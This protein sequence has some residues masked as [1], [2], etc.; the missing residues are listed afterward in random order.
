ME[1]HNIPK[2]YNKK[3]CIFRRNSQ[4]WARFL[5]LRLIVFFE[6]DCFGNNLK[7]AI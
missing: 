1:Q 6:F 2:A 3:L 7:S 5:S 4:T